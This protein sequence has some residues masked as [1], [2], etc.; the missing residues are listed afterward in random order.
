MPP[1][2]HPSIGSPL[3]SN[4]NSNVLKKKQPFIMEQVAYNSKN[5]TSRFTRQKN[6]VLVILPAD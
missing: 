3:R 4:Q 5:T 1:T 6:E 2:N